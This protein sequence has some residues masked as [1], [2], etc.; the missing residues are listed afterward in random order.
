MS[1]ILCNIFIWWRSH[2]HIEM[3]IRKAKDK[4]FL[5]VNFEFL[6]HCLL[7]CLLRGRQSKSKWKQNKKL[8]NI[9]PFFLTQPLYLIKLYLPIFLKIDLC[10]EINF[11]KLKAYLNFY[12]GVGYMGWCSNYFN[13]MMQKWE[14]RLDFLQCFFT[15]LFILCIVVSW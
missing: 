5:T 11:K 8:R 14:N 10:Q 13:M 12:I 1:L 9:Q 4:P 3:K 15:V 6:S 7:A 2:F